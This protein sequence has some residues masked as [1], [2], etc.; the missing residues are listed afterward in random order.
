MAEIK[1]YVCDLG[2]EKNEDDQEFKNEV[3]LVGNASTKRS[4]K[5]CGK[6]LALVTDY[7]LDNQQKN[8]N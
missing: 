8:G 3:I 2:G 6:C 4:W 7:V 5:V 1:Y